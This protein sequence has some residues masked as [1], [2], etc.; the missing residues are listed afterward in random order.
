MNIGIGIPTYNRLESLKRLVDEIEGYCELPYDLYISID[1]SID[2]T[3]PW[4]IENNYE[5]HFQE[6]KGICHVK[7]AILRRFQDYDYFFIVEDDVHIFKSGVFK[8]Y[9]DAI[10]AF[11]IHHF[12]FL[13]PKQRVPLRPNETINGI[14]VL[15]SRLLGGCFSTFTKEVVSKVGAFN[16][17]YIGYGH[18]HTNHTRRVMRAGLAPAGSFVHVVNAEEYIEHSGIPNA[19]PVELRKK[20]LAVNVKVA[21]TNN[22]IFIPL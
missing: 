14:T 17:K 16:P 22:D 13:T 12:N 19:T 4:V 15:Y 10:K 18:G 3:L 20:Q 5:F 8:L 11:G 9:V 6:N 21:A 1:G 7:N 2:G